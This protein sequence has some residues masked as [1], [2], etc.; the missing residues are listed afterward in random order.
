MSP[1]H[2]LRGL[3][4]RTRLAVLVGA[5][6]GAISAAVLV[7]LPTRAEEASLRALTTETDGIAR[8][9]AHTVAPSLLFEDPL[10][11]E[12]VL[13]S[14][15]HAGRIAYVVVEDAYGG[16]FAATALDV[17]KRARYRNRDESSLPSDDFY[18]V[19]WPVE[20]DGRHLGTVY[21]GSPLTPLHEERDA[22]LRATA[23]G[24]AGLLLLGWLAALAIGSFVTRPLREML[25]IA[26]R[27]GSGAIG[28][29]APTGSGG[30][31]GEL[32]GSFNQ[33]LDR[34]QAART[35][36]ETLNQDLERRVA[37][38]TGALAG[39]VAERQRSEQALRSS[40][41]RFL[42]AAAALEGAV[43]DWDGPSNT[44][45]WTEGISRVFGY[46][47]AEVEGT[48]AWWESR[49]HPDDQAQVKQ[50]LVE[51]LRSGRNF[52]AEYR[53]RS[54]G[55]EY[56]HVL[57]R[58]EVVC[59]PAG[60]VTR[61]VGVVENI[62]TLRRLEE[63]Y[64]H[65]Q[66]MDALGRLAGGVAHDFN[67]L[68]TAI[69]GFS[70]LLMISLP[71]GSAEQAHVEEVRKAGQRAAALTHQLL[72]FS[73][74]QVVRPRIIDCNEVVVSL[75]KMLE[76]LIGETIRLDCRLGP[77]ALRVRADRAQL[78]QI[79][80]NVLVNSRDAMPMG[81]AIV[82]AT[83]EVLSEDWPAW[84]EAGARPGRH[85][86][87]TIR[88]NGCGM[89]EPTRVRIFEPFF[90]TKGVGVG[91][92][93][94]MSTV[95]GIVTQCGGAIRV[96]ST[97]GRGTTVAILLPA[98]DEKETSEAPGETEQLARGSET[99]LVV[100][101]EE[102]VRRLMAGLLTTQGYEVLLA[103]SG[104]EGVAAAEAHLGPID[105]VITDVVMPG[106]G[107]RQ[108]VEALQRRRPGVPAL[109]VSGYNDDTILQHGVSSD[110]VPL[111]GKPFARADLLRR[112]RD[113]LDSRAKAPALGTTA[114]PASGRRGSG[115]A[116]PA[117]R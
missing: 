52:A 56:L 117:Q 64:L 24:G 84:V 42:L 90:T 76:R 44:V 87:L 36:L 86:M 79:I 53:F 69:L 46:P 49:V 77:G 107:G 59:N 93:L 35:E 97:P 11:A 60:R 104:E 54:S 92:G 80:V 13:A 88:D 2:L 18:R 50:R 81:G 25:E 78:E 75:G 61:M 108:M 51:S 43:Y 110:Q 74:K 112:V 30:E 26:Q 71:A 63:Q 91:T 31:A 45:E 72:T 82:L 27:I 57:D 1:L 73:R 8:M 96:D 85:V 34:L 28:L 67:N 98:V 83:S 23:L 55:G 111:L 38:R 37:E 41:D 65:S 3:K 89:D 19:S 58:G 4:I 101:D 14:A 100:E 115:V 106:M 21:L 68:L 17:A 95:Y 48:R 7:F 5:L 22:I 113:L 6:L 15:R 94:G 103:R 47:L 114:P 10:S 40:N 70:D 99:L 16:V 62:S 116:P 33:M 32:A 105:L 39:E 29:R 102:G 66:R 20:S 12:E 9:T 109:F